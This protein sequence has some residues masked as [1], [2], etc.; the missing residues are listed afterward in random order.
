MRGASCCFCR[1]DAIDG[2]KSFD[3]SP[4]S[5]RMNIDK[6]GDGDRILACKS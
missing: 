2:P 1:M 4:N 6:S 3:T 5:L